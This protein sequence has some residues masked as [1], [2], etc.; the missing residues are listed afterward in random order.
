MENKRLENI[1]LR[2]VGE[3]QEFQFKI[4]DERTN[5][6]LFTCS[7]FVQLWGNFDW[8]QMLFILC[9]WLLAGF[10]RYNLCTRLRQW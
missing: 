10:S 5:V 2:D 7:F 6:H 3:L 9:F 1:A 4:V 8:Q